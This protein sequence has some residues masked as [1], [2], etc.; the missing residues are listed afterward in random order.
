MRAILAATSLLVSTQA[1][2]AEYQG[3][4]GGWDVFKGDEDCGASMEFEGPGATHLTIIREVDDATYAVINNLDWSARKGADYEVTFALN[5]TAYTGKAIGTSDNGIRTGFIARFEP[6]FVDDFAKGSGLRVFLGEQRIDDLS[7]AGTAAA[8]AAVSRC[9][10]KV[11]AEKAAEAREKAR[12]ADLPKDPFAPPPAPPGER[13]LAQPINPGFWVTASDF[14][15]AALREERGGKVS[16]RAIVTPEGRASD[17]QITSSSGHA[18]LD[19]HTCAL[20][21]RRARFKPAIDTIGEP[22]EGYFDSAVNW[23]IPN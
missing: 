19:S 3:E 5:G 21:V 2:A 8:M 16:F 12:W 15:S 14:P 22:T 20:V 9:L 17:C 11:R 23:E 7:L 6:G 13:G 18:D 4:F 10:A 1:M